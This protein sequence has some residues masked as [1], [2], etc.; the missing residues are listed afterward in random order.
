MKNITVSVHDKTYLQARVHAAWNN[1][2]VSA[3][4][5]QFLETLDDPS[6]PALDPPKRKKRSKSAIFPRF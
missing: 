1:T 2:S 3:L 5:R 6:D 4:F